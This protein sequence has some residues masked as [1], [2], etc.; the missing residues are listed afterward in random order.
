MRRPPA[1]D[2]VLTG[3]GLVMTVIV[4]DFIVEFGPH[5]IY[6]AYVVIHLGLS[7][8]LLFRSL[9]PRT[10]FVVTYGLLAALASL[11]YVSPVNLGVTPMLLCAPL[12]LAV[13]TRRLKSPAWGVSALLIGIVASFFSP[14]R[15]G[16][17]WP[18]I[19]SG[20]ITAHILILVIVY[21]WASARKRAEQEHQA[22]LAAQAASYESLLRVRETQAAAREREKIARE[23][24]DIV[25]HSL[26]VV[27]VQAST[28]LALDRPDQMKEALTQ[29]SASSK[30]A[31]GEV[32][33]L[34]SLLRT[35][36]SEPQLEP[37][38]GNL[39]RVH[40]MIADA[41]RTGITIDAEVPDRNALARWQES[42]PAMT[43][44]TVLR[45]L[46]EALTNVVK[47]AGTGAR[48]RVRITTDEE[49]CTIDVT[50]TI[51]PSGAESDP[52]SA[53]GGFGLIGLRERLHL[54]E[55]DFTAGP[56]NLASIFRRGLGSGA[57]P[58]G[59]RCS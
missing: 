7:G 52:A 19:G 48:A 54:I 22:E 31:L 50:N 20:A 17:E 29:I 11:Y 42:W 45:V 32:R 33:S 12:S 55:G 43:S 18:N 49:F 37:P 57:C 9:L 13:V 59:E 36:A 47:H 26:T 28:A 58:D 41:E 56:E 24:H 23:V 46:Q 16:G 25:A 53:G 3:L 30:A 44:L 27:Q 2:L 14:V 5:P 21:L 8:A 34:V 40:A 38:S 39:D 1:L 6:V 10:S 51:K 15:P 4:S 35:R